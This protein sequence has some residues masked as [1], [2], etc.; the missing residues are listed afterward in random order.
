MNELKYSKV[1]RDGILVLALFLLGAIA[2]IVFPI[3][4]KFQYDNLVATMKSIEA[5][6][7]D[8]DLDINRYGPDEQEI[9]ITY[10]VDDVVYNRELSTDTKIAF[11]A[12]EG[13][14][15][16]VGDTID[17]FY[18]PQNPNQI[19]TPRSVKVG[20]GYL[21]VGLIVFVLAMVGLVFLLKNRRKFLVTK[22]EYEKEKRERK[23]GELLS[24][25]GKR[26]RWQYFN[27]FIYF[28]LSSIPA[29][30]AM[31]IAQELRKGNFD[32]GNTIVE[33][34][35]ATPV[36]LVMYLIFIGPFVILS[37]LNRFCF[38]KVL[39]VVNES[40]LYLKGREIYVQD[41][42][43]IVY[44]PRIMSRSSESCSY[45]AFMVRSKNGGTESFVEE[46]FPLYGLREI[47]KQNPAIKLRL[48]KSVLL[49]A[50]LPT[51][52]FAVL[53]FLMG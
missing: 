4:S 13:A 25:N 33:M 29:V 22:E 48:K 6:I 51:A 35:G 30:P 15:Y 50:L 34:A 40:T 37:I 10:E 44:H 41:I 26:I 46:H 43:E 1:F 31:L 8:I 5:T 39:G 2:L 42:T 12:G 49:L 32:I 53:G 27:V 28:L 9:Y 47:K 52:A 45:A 23:N 11:S 21:V 16:R 17:I 19:A 36:V 38:G 14:H 18:N 24:K 3:L 7:V 20:Y